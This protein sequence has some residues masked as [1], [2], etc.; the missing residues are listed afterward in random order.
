MIRRK[1]TISVCLVAFTRRLSFRSRPPEPV[2]AFD[3]ASGREL[4]WVDP[5]CDTGVRYGEGFADRRALRHA[6]FF[7]HQ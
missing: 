6:D 1:T 5:H 4:W 3:P 7:E 2:A